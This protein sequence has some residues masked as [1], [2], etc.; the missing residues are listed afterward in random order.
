MRRHEPCPPEAEADDFP[1]CR[2]NLRMKTLILIRHAKSSWDDLSLRD[3]DRDLNK[4][5]RRDAPEMG[6]RLAARYAILDAFV[7]STACRARATAELMAGE[8]DFPPERIEFRD[9]LYLASPST[10]LDVIRQ[11]PDSV[12]TL[13]LLAHNPGITELANRLSGGRR[14]DNMPTSGVATFNLSADSWRQIGGGAELIDFDYP[15]R[16]E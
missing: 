1:D 3:F 6:R 7:V 11:V 15:K 12:Q 5:G 10:M 2:Y 13:A 8:L 16:D 4:R 14:I 9:E